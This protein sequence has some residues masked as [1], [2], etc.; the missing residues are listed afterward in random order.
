L[1]RSSRIF[2]WRRSWSPVAATL[3]A[4]LARSEPLLLALAPPVT[5]SP[6]VS[7]DALPATLRL[8]DI[9]ASSASDYDVLL[10]GGAS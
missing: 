3:D 1:F 7:S 6:I 5:P 8:L 10:L 9:A 4:A 2:L